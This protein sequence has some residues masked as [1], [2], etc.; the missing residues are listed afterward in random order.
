MGRPQQHKDLKEKKR[1]TLIRVFDYTMSAVDTFSEWILLHSAIS[2][3][4]DDEVN[5]ILNSLFT[6]VKDIARLYR[7]CYG[8]Y[9][10]DMTYLLD[11]VD[12]ASEDTD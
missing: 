10:D 7:K 1:R 8:A 5:A 11:I 12:F 6:T 3:E 2:K 4:D 9:T